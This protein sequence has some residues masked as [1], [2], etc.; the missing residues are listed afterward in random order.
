MQV[1][2]YELREALRNWVTR[3]EILSKQFTKSLWAFP[4]E[5]TSANPP[6][7]VALRFQVADRNVATLEEAQQY[8]NLQV[9]VCLNCFKDEP[10]SV[11]TLSRAVKLVGGAGRY[12]KMWR[13]AAVDTGDGNRWGDR[14]LVRR[15]DETKA[16]R[17][18]P[19]DQCVR[20]AERASKFA[21]A[22]RSGIAKANTSFI[23]IP[24]L[25]QDLFE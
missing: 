20:L 13:T 9:K 2:G 18:V 1:S 3:R 15:N 22:L 17:T 23:E 14:D 4:G 19:I 6:E 7:G 10:P 24:F 12:E 16:E 11:Y 5:D 21:N 25:T 8:Y